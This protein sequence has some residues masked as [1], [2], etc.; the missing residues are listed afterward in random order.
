MPVAGHLLFALRDK[1]GL[2]RVRNALPGSVASPGGASGDGDGDGR[3]A[4]DNALKHAKQEVARR[5]LLA[6]PEEPGYIDVDALFAATP[7]ADGSTR[8]AG[9]AAT[10]TTLP[11]KLEICSGSGDW[12]VAHAAAD[13]H[14]GPGQPARARWLALELRCDRAHQTLSKSV[15]AHWEHCAQQPLPQW[16]GTGPSPFGGLPNLAILSGDATKV[17][18]RRLAPASIA[19]LYVNHPEPPERTSGE[20][21]SQ[22]AHLLTQAF[23][24]EMHRVLADDGT[25]TIVTDNLPYGESLLR[26]VAKTAHEVL[27][28]RR[29]G[30]GCSGRHPAGR[31]GRMKTAT[32]GCGLIITAT[33]CFTSHRRGSFSG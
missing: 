27:T 22:G 30:G 19:A 8:A 29:R 12:V 24:G 32:A 7:G 2:D 5:V 31:W 16:A 11:V 21:E 25:L 23:F 13:M 18:P 3:K 17:L 15:A 28:K 4:R 1:F 14:T 20:G 26:A 33:G 9:G 6:V 10:T